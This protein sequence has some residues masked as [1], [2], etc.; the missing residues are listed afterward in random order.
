MNKLNQWMSTD[1]IFSRK[2][3]FEK[4]HNCISNLSWLTCGP[5]ISKGIYKKKKFL[6]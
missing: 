4:Y 3:I 6:L 5:G 2:D 1:G